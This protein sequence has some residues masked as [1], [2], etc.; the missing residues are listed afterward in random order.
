MF[1]SK[2]DGMGSDRKMTSGGQVQQPP[3]IKNKWVKAFK[4]IKGK[5]SPSPGATPNSADR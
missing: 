3:T 1:S 5:D 4:S 2:V